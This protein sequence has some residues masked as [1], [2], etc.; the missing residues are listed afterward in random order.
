MTY[1]LTV[2]LLMAVLPIGSILIER[3]AIGNSVDVLL[4]VGKWFVFWAVGVRQFLAGIRQV[5]RPQFTSEGIFGIK[6]KEPWAIVR[7]L[8]FANLS[9]GVLGIASIVVGGLTKP[10]AI[11]SG[12]FFGIAGINHCIRKERT[13]AENVATVS[14][15]LLFAILLL[16]LILAAIGA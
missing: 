16:Y 11:V 2:V 4:L 10:S 14:D 5:V 1:L 8:G 7:E 13:F 3:F 15:L 12:L 9:M 6:T